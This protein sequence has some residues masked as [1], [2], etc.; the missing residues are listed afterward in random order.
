MWCK[1]DQARQGSMQQ[2]HRQLL[3]TNCPTLCAQAMS[4]NS[5][6][7]VTNAQLVYQAGDIGNRV[8][9]MHSAIQEDMKDLLQARV[10]PLIVKVSPL[11][12]VLVTCALRLSDGEILGG[13]LKGFLARSSRLLEGLSCLQ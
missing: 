6:I 4:V 2:K 1:E 5:C 12:D 10:S 9:A 13:T 7:A 8:C 11:Y 3:T